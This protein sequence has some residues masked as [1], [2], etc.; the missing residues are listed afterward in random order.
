MPCQAGYF[1]ITMSPKSRN[2]LFTRFLIWRTKHLSLQQ[3]VMILAALIGFTAGLAAVVIK[4]LTHFIQ[5]LLEGELIVNYHH[6]FYF[7]FPLSLIHI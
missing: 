1:F 7:I 5:R 3:F 6:A 4:N 2:P